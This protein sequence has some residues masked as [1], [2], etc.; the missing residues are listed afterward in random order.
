MVP[1]AGNHHGGPIPRHGNIENRQ[2]PD[3]VTVLRRDREGCRPTPVVAYDEKL[4]SAKDLMSQA[5]DV[6]PEGL[7]VIATHGAG[8]IAQAT[9]IRGDHEIVLSESGDDVTPHVP[10]L[11]PP[12]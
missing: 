8:R 6:L 5:P 3:G 12:M 11:R 7:L 4:V 1:A 9:Q 10:R 2:P